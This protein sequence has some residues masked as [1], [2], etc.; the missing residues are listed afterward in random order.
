MKILIASDFNPSTFKDLSTDK[1]VVY[2]ELL[3]LFENTDLHIVNLEGSLYKGAPIKKQGPCLFIDRKYL[4]LLWPKRTIMCLA[5]NHF[6]DY[7][8]A[9]RKETLDIIEEKGIKHIG[10]ITPSIQIK[11]TTIYNMCESEV[12]TKGLSNWD[13]GRIMQF[14]C[15]TKNNLV[16]LHGGTEGFPYPTRRQKIEWCRIK[17]ESDLVVG[18]HNHIPSVF[19][20]NIYYGLGNFLFKSRFSNRGYFVIYDTDTKKSEIVTYEIT[21]SGLKKVDFRKDLE[22]LNKRNWYRKWQEYAEMKFNKD[23]KRLLIKFLNEDKLIDLLNFVQCESHRD[24]II[25]GANRRTFTKGEI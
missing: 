19:K 22:E 2:G 11:E 10:C 18:H 14:L 24:I 23:Y 15:R 12:G 3:S 5:N 4:D 6:A 25:E 16:I 8:F 9:G 17:Q 20:D 1:R 13:M 21:E 7:G